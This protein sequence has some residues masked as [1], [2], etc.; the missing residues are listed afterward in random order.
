MATSLRELALNAVLRPL[1]QRIWPGYDEFLDPDYNLTAHGVELTPTK[2]QEFL[3]YMVNITRDTQP[4]HPDTI[5]RVLE[6]FVLYA[7][8]ALNH[9]F[10]SGGD[11]PFE[12]SPVAELLN[13]KLG[14]LVM[15]SLGYWCT[16]WATSLNFTSFPQSTRS[17][18]TDSLFDYARRSRKYTF[19]GG[20]RFLAM[21]G[22]TT[23]ARVNL[24]S[25]IEQLVAEVKAAVQS[26]VKCVYANLRRFAT[27]EIAGTLSRTAV[28]C[29]ASFESR[30][31]YHPYSPHWGSLVRS[32]RQFVDLYVCRADPTSPCDC[33]DQFAHTCYMNQLRPHLNASVC[34]GLRWQPGLW[35]TEHIVNQNYHRPSVTRFTTCE[36]C[37]LD[38]L[39]SGGQLRDWAIV[40]L[41]I[42][43]K[44]W[45]PTGVYCRNRFNATGSAADQREALKCE[46][47]A[48]LAKFYEFHAEREP[49][50]LFADESLSD[51]EEE[52]DITQQE[53]DKYLVIDDSDE[54]EY[55][56][57]EY[58]DDEYELKINKLIE[59]LMVAPMD[60]P[61]PFLTDLY[62][63]LE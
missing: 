51:D 41:N 2:Q 52:C 16:V 42:S 37:L 27:S 10:N 3:D 56:D 40:P 39:T 36:Y 25:G 4:A 13:K 54:E 57:D 43:Y 12:T 55:T 19:T 23:M 63:N 58:T 45:Y 46:P 61:E 21:Y 8:E 20:E 24:K 18:T 44:R 31:K 48:T 26:P 9:V 6:D 17:D 50:R 5:F 53:M 14:H 7:G 32:F 60:I 33:P 22:G 1:K 29:V 62:T 47:F 28:S 30:Y 35:H 49:S 34:G 59:D 11:K 15:L 38:A